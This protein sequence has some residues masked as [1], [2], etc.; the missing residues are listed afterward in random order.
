[1][2]SVEGLRARLGGADVLRGASVAVPGCSF[3]GL[4]GRNG[5]GKTTLLRTVM[6][7]V[8]ATSGRV[9]LEGRDVLGADASDRARQGVGYMPED[10]RLVPALTVRDNILLPSMAMRLPRAQD[11]L[12]EIVEQIPEL[13]TMLDRKATSVSGGQQKLVALA[14]AMLSGQKLLLLDEPTEGVAPALAKRIVEVLRALKRAGATIF[15]AESNAG[16]IESL[17]DAVYTIERGVARHA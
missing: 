6:G 10:R 1:M 2:S 13:S 4:V 16:H 17:C 3:V 8:P 5:A 15:V 9:R 7:L 11:R 14:R 12:A